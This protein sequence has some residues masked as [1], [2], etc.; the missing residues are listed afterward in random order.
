MP[1]VESLLAVYDAQLRPAETRNLPPGVTAEADG[2]VVRLVGKRRGF[3]SGPTY[4]GLG[5]AAL[6]ELI[7]RQR[8]FFAERGEAVEWKIRGHDRPPDLARRLAWAGFVAEDRETVVVGLTE[9][10]A[11][12]EP[13]LPADVVVRRL[14]EDADLHRVAALESEIWGIDLSRLGNELVA[15]VRGGTGRTVVLAAEAGDRLVSVA[16]LTFEPGTEFAGLWGGCTLPDWRGRGIYRTLVAQR[17]RLA[18]ERGV[19]YLQADASDHS[20][21]TLQRLGFMAVTTTTPY[22]WTPQG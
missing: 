16:W 9:H 19:R 12:A 15:Q 10:L 7:E 3:V 20:L 2:P 22:V 18:V 14:T 17:A 21:P 6:D 4:I 13:P 5:G 8:D 1:D 11:R